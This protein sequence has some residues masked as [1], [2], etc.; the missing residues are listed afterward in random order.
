DEQWF[1]ILSPFDIVKAERRNYD[2]HIE[3]L[4]NKKKF[5]EAIQAFEKPLNINE[6]PK[7]Y[8]KQ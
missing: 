8:T 2:D 4:I 7:K 5:D 3:Y 6:K 1:F